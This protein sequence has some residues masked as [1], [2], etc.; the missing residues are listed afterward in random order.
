MQPLK[1]SKQ[2]FHEKITNN[3]AQEN[4]SSVTC[5]E[6][7]KSSGAPD[8]YRDGFALNFLFVV[9]FVSRQRK[10]RGPG[11]LLVT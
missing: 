7:G 9:F 2:T 8:S 11:Q 5:A 4:R 6:P 1:R 10:E 3:D